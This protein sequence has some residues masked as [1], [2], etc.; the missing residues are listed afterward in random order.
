MSAASCLRCSLIGA[1]VVGKALINLIISVYFHLVE[2][3][4][5]EIVLDLESLKVL[6]SVPHLSST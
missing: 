5:P 2:K 3:V 6:V 1:K 4:Y